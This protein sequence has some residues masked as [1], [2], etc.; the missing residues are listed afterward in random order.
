M[1]Y[2]KDA[3]LNIHALESEDFLYLLPPECIEITEEEFMVI[4][5]EKN[6]PTADQLWSEYKAKAQLLLDATDLVALRCWKAG[7]PYPTEWLIYTNK[8]RDIVRSTSGNPC[9]TF[10]D[11]PAYPA[12]T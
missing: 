7:V 1:K 10:P 11:I 6:S 5:E 8:L 2:Y 4:T 9:N 3:N 12:G